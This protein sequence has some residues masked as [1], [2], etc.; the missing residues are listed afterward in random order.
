[1]AV[2]GRD[3]RRLSPP[4]LQC[5]SMNRAT[6]DF[7]RSDNAFLR[8]GLRRVR[9]SDR[10]IDWAGN[11]GWCRTGEVVGELV[12]EFRDERG[13][14]CGSVKS[15]RSLSKKSGVLWTPRERVGECMRQI[16]HDAKQNAAVAPAA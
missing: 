15:C 12:E 8:V 7:I 13:L 1:M 6:Q 2:N 5:A 16:I 11:G 4:G 14:P 10:D 9:G 3:S